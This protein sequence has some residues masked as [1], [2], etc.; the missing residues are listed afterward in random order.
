[1]EKGDIV[2][3][4][5]SGGQKVFAADGSLKSSRGPSA[6]YIVY[7]P[8]GVMIVVSTS[9]EGVCAADPARMSLAEKAAAADNCTAYCGRY[10]FSNGVVLHHVEAAI[11]PAWVGKTRVRHAS[12]DGRRMTFVTEPA[13]D[14]SVSHIYWDRV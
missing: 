8:E 7:T 11:F 13:A 3:A 6:G 12:L 2:G 5:R 1:M 4:W 10:E 9:T 14:G